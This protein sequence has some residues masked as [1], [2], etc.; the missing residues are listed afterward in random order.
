MSIYDDLLGKLGLAQKPEEE[1]NRAPAS[2]PEV[3]PL[4]PMAASE[5]YDAEKRLAQYATPRAADY[6][7]PTIQI[8]QGIDN[9]QAIKDMETKLNILNGQHKTD[10]Q[11]AED[12]KFNS[13]IFAALGN[14]LPGAVAGATAM[15]THAAVKTP[16]VPKIV[17]AD[18]TARVDAKYKT[19]YEGMLAKYKALKDGAL[20]PKDE[21]YRNIAQAQLDTKAFGTNANIQNTDR[22]AGIRVENAIRSDKEKNELSDKQT[23]EITDITNTLDEIRGVHSRAGG[24]KDKLG[25]TISKVEEAKEGFAG[26]VVR[27]V[28]GPI[29]EQYVKFRSDAKA[30]QGAYQKLISGL[31]VSEAERKEL[32]SY[33]PNADMPY[34]SFKANAEAFERRAQQLLDKKLGSMKKFQGKNVGGYSQDEAPKANEVERKTADGKTAIFDAETK[35]FLRYK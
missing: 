32:R 11:D 14:Y 30:L 16:D 18:P 13:E 22:N 12:R 1:A 7:A 25:P 19:D 5:E 27:A 2:V 17:A 26:P 29:D 28:A 34:A 24:F 4:S 10:L 9:S 31:T 8:P 21:L 23:G 6:K 15:N 35:K 20:T 3:A 33:I